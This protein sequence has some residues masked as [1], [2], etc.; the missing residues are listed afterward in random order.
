MFVFG[1]KRQIY[2]ALLGRLGERTK[3]LSAC[4]RIN[5]TSEY[6]NNVFHRLL[7]TEFF[8]SFKSVE[9]SFDWQETIVSSE[10]SQ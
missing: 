6:S 2:F 3:Y 5:V 4:Y 8:L 9:L 1:L 7:T 10:S